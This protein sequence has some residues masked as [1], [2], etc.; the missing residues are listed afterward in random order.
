MQKM[1]HLKTQL[2]ILKKMQKRELNKTLEKSKKIEAKQIHRTLE[3]A[4]EIPHS[5]IH[6]I[7]YIIFQF[8]SK[9]KFA[10]SIYNYKKIVNS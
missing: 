5:L 2:I 6:K 4:K 7:H 3:K 1:G 9:T 8:T 10:T